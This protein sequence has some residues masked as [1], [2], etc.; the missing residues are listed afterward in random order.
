MSDTLHTDDAE[1]SAD[2][3]QAIE[4]ENVVAADALRDIEDGQRVRVSTLS[5]EVEG[6][7]TH[8]HSME[9]WPDEDYLTTA[10]TVEEAEG[11]DE[12]ELLLGEDENS[13]RLVLA[14][15]S[16]AFEDEYVLS[17]E[18]VSDE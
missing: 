1:N 6:T 14:S 16:L 8:L 13:D 9:E 3:N 10:L 18:V 2:K 11:C 7:V 17:L 4:M 5:Y 12:P 15:V